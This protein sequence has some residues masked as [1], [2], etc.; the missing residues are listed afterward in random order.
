MM[1]RTVH[2]TNFRIQVDKSFL[3]A[4]YFLLP[5]VLVFVV[6]ILIAEEWSPITFLSIGARPIHMK[7]SENYEAMAR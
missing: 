1:Q 3:S 6:D 4:V 2:F 7:R 5:P